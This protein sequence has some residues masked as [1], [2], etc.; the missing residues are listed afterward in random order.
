M[1]LAGARWLARRCP[2]YR[3]REPDLLLLHGMWEG[4]SRILPVR[5]QRRGGER[6]SVVRRKPETLST[7]AGPAGGPAR[8]SGETSV[9]GVERRGRLIGE[10]FA[11]ATGIVPGGDEWASQVWQTSRL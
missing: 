7:D 5:A 4:G 2:A 10:L 9:M 1:S 6:E 11:R 8:S 3:R